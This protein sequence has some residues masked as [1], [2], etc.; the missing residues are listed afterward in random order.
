[1]PGSVSPSFDKF[2]A[3]VER[4]EEIRKAREEALKIQRELEEQLATESAVNTDI[5]VRRQV[6]YRYSTFFFMMARADV[7][8]F[9]LIDRNKMTVSNCA[10]MN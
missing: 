6:Y 9:I 3:V 2:Q 5:Q 4:D 7:L 10:K 8:V 1:M